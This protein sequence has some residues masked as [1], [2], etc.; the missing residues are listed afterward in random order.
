MSSKNSSAFAG[1]VAGFA[2]LLITTTAFLAA[3]SA[4]L[5]ADTLKTGLEFVAVLISWYTIR[6][7]SGPV[8]RNFQYGIGKLENISSLIIAM[9]MASCIVVIIVNSVK[10]IIH[11]SHI[12]GF[13]IWI[14]MGTQVVYGFV[15]TLFFVKNRAIA[16]RESSPL[17]ESQSKF[18]FTKAIANGFIFTS[19]TLSVIL[20]HYGWVTF[21][22]PVSS[23]LIAGS[24]LLSA[25]GILSTSLQDLLDRSIEE[26]AQIVILRTLA[27]HFEQYDLLHGIRSR[28]SGSNVF[29]EIFLEF[30]PERKIGEA[31]QTID[32]I[33]DN[34]E[35]E[36]I[37]SRVSVG[38]TCRDEC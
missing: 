36:I 1:V 11:P 22:D 34:I 27:E 32:S 3:N 28:R 19:L 20:P 13:G 33:R 6:K 38:L 14:S 24:I 35:K 25:F 26:S 15:N 31:Q 5:L 29:V 23:L 16:K 30:N 17:M 12:S 18:F 21:I 4:V 8:N 9:L 2:D 7:V 37:G 10:G